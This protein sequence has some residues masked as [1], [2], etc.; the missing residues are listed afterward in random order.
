M[1]TI[2][3]QKRP[4]AGGCRRADVGRLPVIIEE[5][6]IDKKFSP[7]EFFFPHQKLRRGEAPKSLTHQGVPPYPRGVR[8]SSTGYFTTRRR[9]TSRETLTG[10]RKRSR[11]ASSGNRRSNRHEQM[12]GHFSMTKRGQNKCRL[13]AGS[14]RRVSARFWPTGRWGDTSGGSRTAV[15][16]STQADSGHPMRPRNP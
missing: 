9:S 7:P 2:L 5:S 15:S 16:R 14:T 11:P 6:A 10:S 1:G 3:E 12:G 13:T 4:T 8:S